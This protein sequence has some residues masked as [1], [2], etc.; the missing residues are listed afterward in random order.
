MAKDDLGSIAGRFQVVLVGFSILVGLIIL[1]WQSYAW[2]RTGYWIQ[3][4]LSRAFGYIGVN[5]ARV[6]HPS[7]GDWQSVAK[8]ARWL[9]A[10]PMTLSIPIITGI[11]SSIMRLLIRCD[12]LQDSD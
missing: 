12:P 10:W 3:M 9:L 5:L 8:L 6:Y 1:G 2:L 7:P 11:L 4:P